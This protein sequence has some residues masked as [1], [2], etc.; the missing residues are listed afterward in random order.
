MSSSALE[1]QGTTP[2]TG[3]VEREFTVKARSQRQQIV[4]RFLHNKQAMGGLIVLTIMVVTAFVGP[5]FYK[6][7]YDEFDPTSRSVGPGENGHPLGTQ[8]LGQD[9]L[10]LLMRGVQRSALIVVLVVS[11]AMCI[12]LII[13]SLAGYYS[14]W[15][16][17][18]LMRLVDLVLTLPLLII[19]VVVASAFE[20]ARTAVGVGIILGCFGWS[21][22]ARLT[23]A[24]F[25]SLRERE[26]IEAAHALGAKDRRIIFKHLIPNT[27]GSII[28]WATLTAAVAVIL[29]ASLTYLGY[30][31]QGNDTSLGRLVS[32]GAAAA[33][34]RPWL[35]YF[36]GLT[37]LILVM[38]IN[39]VGD[40]IRDAFD[41]SH[42]RVRA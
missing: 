25:M 13:G 20:S 30:G 31:V 41:P 42:K 23:R 37:L 21:D 39:L 28:V 10:A 9:V 19:I 36:P 17:N 1:T 27:L 14:R 18:L 15:V 4:Q 22:L 35:F 3:T 12:G 26:F 40:G 11:I 29:E 34:S 33:S 2:D 7:R 16:D 8:E 6:Y 32:D 24:Q 38:S 5:M